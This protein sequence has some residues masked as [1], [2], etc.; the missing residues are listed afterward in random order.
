MGAPIA[1]GESLHALT[2]IDLGDTMAALAGI[3]R[4]NIRALWELCV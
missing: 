3:S 4:A 1:D 2:A